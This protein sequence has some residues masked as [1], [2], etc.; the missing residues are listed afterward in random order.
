M[1][2]YEEA[3]DNDFN[4]QDIVAKIM[5]CDDKDDFM[6]IMNDFDKE[7]LTDEGRNK[8]NEQHEEKLQWNYSNKTQNSLHSILKN[9]SGISIYFIK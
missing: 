9:K 1:S 5:N 2:S 4:I 8:Q 6:K 7:I 3:Y